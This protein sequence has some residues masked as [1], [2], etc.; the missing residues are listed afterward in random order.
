MTLLLAPGHEISKLLVALQFSGTI[1]K[2][3]LIRMV[4]SLYDQ[5]YGSRNLEDL[6]ATLN[7]IFPSLCD[8][9]NPN[10]FH[11]IFQIV[12]D[13]LLLMCVGSST[14][15]AAKE[16]PRCELYE[17]PLEE[18]DVGERKE[19]VTIEPSDDEDSG[20]EVSLLSLVEKHRQEL[21]ENERKTAAADAETVR[22]KAALAAARNVC[23]KRTQPDCKLCSQSG[24]TTVTHLGIRRLKQ[25][26]YC[27]RNN[28]GQR[29]LYCM[30]C[31][32]IHKTSLH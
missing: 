26:R 1:P 21:D 10:V 23:E 22:L 18:K 16:D 27:P 19:D 9:N 17:P 28:Y 3:Q 29:P 7:E 30:R 14:D 31:F 4:Q 6:C 12:S 2:D 32:N 13:S 8:E 20:G 15:G 24:I 25:C 5:Q 11:E